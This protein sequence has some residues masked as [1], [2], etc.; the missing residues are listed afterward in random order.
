[1]CRSEKCRLG[2]RL[3]CVVGGQLKAWATTI[4]ASLEPLTGLRVFGYA[5][6]RKVW[7]KVSSEL[8]QDRRAW[9]ASVRDAISS[10][11]DAGS[12]RLG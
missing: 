2:L 6:W 3:L 5:R 7:V 11:G 8:A 1:M 9:S 10:I 12:T 4:K